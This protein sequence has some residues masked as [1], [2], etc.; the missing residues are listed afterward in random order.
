MSV[1]ELYRFYHSAG[2][3]TVALRGAGLHVEA[4]E[5]VALMGPSGSGKSTLLACI[6][7]L[8]EPDGGVVEI[9]GERMSRRPER[10]RAKLRARSV[11]MLMQSGNLLEH[12]TVSAN[13][14]VQRQLAG[15]G[16]SDGVDA[17]L[18]TLGLSQRSNAYPST[19]SGGEA[20]R[21]GLAVALSAAPPLLI[22]DEP[23]AEV[24][25][26]TEKAIVQLLQNQ[27][28]SGVAVLVATHSEA[29]A[30][31]ADRIVRLDNGKVITNVA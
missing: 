24:D 26:E 12:L 10:D 4:G 9:G 6:A 3:E 28:R 20:S 25:R 21:A 13:M 17:L 30:A 31:A 11:G 1:R 5:M 22:C 7:G 16:N 2:E 15:R 23:T 27:A 8:D 29:L 14:Q 18:Q 19:L